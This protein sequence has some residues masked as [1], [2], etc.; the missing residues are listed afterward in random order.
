M[1]PFSRRSGDDRRSATSGQQGRPGRPARPARSARP[2]HESRSSPASTGPSPVDLPDDAPLTRQL[3]ALTG[4]GLH[5][6]D[7]VDV[8]ELRRRVPSTGPTPL[9]LQLLL[10]G[11]GR[12]LER[13]VRELVVGDAHLP[14]GATDDDAAASVR[15][16]LAS[17]E[18]ALGA[19]GHV[20]EVEA[21]LDG[22]QGSVTVALGGTPLTVPL[23]GSELAPVLDALLAQLVPPRL[24]AVP[25]LRSTP[26]D[27]GAGDR[28]D[29]S[30]GPTSGPGSSSGSGAGHGSDYR[31]LLVPKEHAREARAIAV[32]LSRAPALDLAT[33]DAARGATSDAS[34]DDSAAGTT[35]S[36]LDG[37]G[38][39]TT[40]DGDI[41]GA[42]A[43]SD[44]EAGRDV[45]RRVSALVEAGLRLDPRLSVD[46]VADAVVPVADPA[47]WD[48]FLDAV[49]HHPVR[50]DIPV[51]SNVFRFPPED[52]MADSSEDWIAV[53]GEIA[54]TAG[55]WDRLTDAQV[56]YEASGEIP[57]G[58]DLTL[59]GRR[60]RVEADVWGALLDL[61]AVARLCE[62]LTPPDRATVHLPNH[63]A[64]VQPH[65]AE[66]LSRL[67]GD[68]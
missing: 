5:L 18:E 68:Y 58:I 51:W 43:S 48:P 2:G 65:R 6:R 27:A 4:L 66:A 61:V 35:P 50:G 34:A 60:T 21:T 67:V 59:K 10:L 1:W 40:P 9:P 7:G 8:D 20:G 32:R 22:D 15:R 14:A 26:D 42:T 29:D 33:S 16:T 62:A 57:A 19:T 53:V 38:P 44:P 55:T 56:V 24:V 49:V 17:A 12:S 64:W 39:T 25:L 13:P 63:A 3:A 41:P 54:R 31:R 36:T 47:D 30:S 37:L 52:T 23:E 28:D 45:R 46:Q 11:A